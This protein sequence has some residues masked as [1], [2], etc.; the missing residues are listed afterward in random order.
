MTIISKCGF[1]EMDMESKIFSKRWLCNKKMFLLKYLVG[2]L[3]FFYYFAISVYIWV[4]GFILMLFWKE[5]V[6]QSCLGIILLKIFLFF[7]KKKMVIKINHYF[8]YYNNQ[9]MQKLM[10][11]MKTVQKKIKKNIQQYN[12]KEITYIILYNKKNKMFK[13]TTFFQQKQSIYVKTLSQEK[14]DKQ[15]LYKT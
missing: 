7:L 6:V 9:T 11:K 14:I 2:Y 12:Q 10:I 1:M 5:I 15:E 8:F 4:Q 13:K 3:C